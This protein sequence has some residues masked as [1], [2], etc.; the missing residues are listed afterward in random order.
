MLN[1]HTFEPD[2][3]EHLGGS[4]SG[5][6]RVKMLT[7]MSSREGEEEKER[8][9]EKLDVIVANLMADV[10]LGSDRSGGTVKERRGEQ[11]SPYM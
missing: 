7:E 2:V 8:E 1:V 10:V 5:E 9:R 4:Q 6:S 3:S 11:Q